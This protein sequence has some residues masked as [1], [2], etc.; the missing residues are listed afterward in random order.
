MDYVCFFRDPRDDVLRVRGMGRVARCA[1]DYERGALELT[2][3]NAF[4]VAQQR[5]WHR[6]R[7]GPT[8]FI[9]GFFDAPTVPLARAG[10]TRCMPSKRA[11]QALFD[12]RDNVLLA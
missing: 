2:D 5:G 9:I 7:M 1:E 4:P 12:I 11:E 8:S 10:V 6:A 3:R